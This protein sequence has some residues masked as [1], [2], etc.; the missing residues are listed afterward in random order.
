MKAN[1]LK[2]VLLFLVVT[3]VLR[4]PARQSEAD[5]QLASEMRAK[6]AEQNLAIAQYPMSQCYAAGQGV[7]K[8]AVEAYKWTFLAAGQGHEEAQNY[9][10]ELESTLLHEQIAEG[11]MRARHFKPSGVPFAEGR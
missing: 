5:P 1:R 6:A 3:A 8:D 4:L 7:A 2:W 10:T 9:R 11:R